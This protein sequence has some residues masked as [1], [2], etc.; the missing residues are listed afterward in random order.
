ML[1]NAYIDTRIE[2]L[3]EPSGSAEQDAAKLVQSVVGVTPA[4]D[5]PPRLFVLFLTRPFMPF[6][7]FVKSVRKQLNKAGLSDVPLIG[8]S[9]AAC[10]F[11]QNV[12]E[13]GAVLIGIASPHLEVSV[14]MAIGADRDAKAAATNLISQLDVESYS[15]G[16]L[17]SSY[18]MTFFPAD[19]SGNSEELI[20]AL[21]SRTGGQ[22][23]MF[24][25]GAVVV[26]DFSSGLIDDGYQ[27]LN[28]DILQGSVVAAFV[29]SELCFGLGVCDG[30][31]KK[32]DMLAKID[33]PASDVIE[34]LEDAKDARGTTVADLVQEHGSLT[35]FKLPGGEVILP[36]DDGTRLRLQGPIRNGTPLSV[37]V[38]DNRR[39]LKSVQDLEEYLAE[40]SY[41]SN[42]KLNAIFAIGSLL[43]YRHRHQLRFNPGYALT[44]AV[45]RHRGAHFVGVYMD[46]EL[47]VDRYGIS[48]LGRWSLAELML[49]DQLT[50]S[51]HNQLA[52]TALSESSGKTPST[53][54]EAISLALD[55]LNLAGYPRGMISM[56]FR[57]GED[58][59]V[60]GQDARGDRWLEPVLSETERKLGT[61]DVLATVAEDGKPVFVAHAPTDPRCACSGEGG[62]AEQANVISFVAIPLPSS[63]GETIG[64]LQVD[65]GDM[66][67]LNDIP[68]SDS[69]RLHAIASFAAT[70]INHAIKAEALE[71]VR[72]LD[73][74]QLDCL[75][76]DT[77]ESGL[78]RFIEEAATFLNVNAHIRLCQEDG[79]LKIIGGK[80]PYYEACL[81]G[82]VSVGFDDPR[83][84][85]SAALDVFDSGIPSIVNRAADEPRHQ[86]KLEIFADTPLG[87]AML[88]VGSYA[89]FPIQTD[90]QKPI[91]TYS[92]NSAERWFFT[93]SKRRSWADIGNRISYLIEHL[94]QKELQNR[95]L[96]ELSFILQITPTLDSQLNVYEALRTLARQIA[97]AANADAASFYLWDEI[98]SRFVL[99][100]QHGWHDE[101]WIDAAWHGH[102]SGLT[103][104]LAVKNSPTH[105]AD[106]TTERANRNLSTS[107]Y[108]N[109]VYP[110]RI[111]DSE[112]SEFIVIPLHFKNRESSAV[113]TLHRRYSRNC[114]PQSRGFTTVD[115]RIL[116]EAA[117]IISA[118]V[119]TLLEHDAIKWKAQEL[120]R[121]QK[122]LRVLATAKPMEKRIHEVCEAIRQEFRCRRCVLY[123][124]SDAKEIVVRVQAPRDG[125]ERVIPDEVVR[126]VFRTQTTERVRSP[127]SENQHDPDSVRIENQIC[128][129]ILPVHAGDRL[130]GVLDMSWVGM[131]N[132]R[133]R[134]VL[135]YHDEAAL[136]DLARQIGNSVHVD[137]LRREAQSAL[138]A[139]DGIAAY[140][141]DNF[142]TE[143]VKTVS[144]IKRKTEN[145]MNWPGP[146]N[147]HKELLQLSSVVNKQY[148]FVNRVKEFSRRFI[149]SRRAEHAI[150]E[151][152][153][154]AAERFRNE[155]DR[156]GIELKMDPV[157]R[158]CSFVDGVQVKEAFE[159]II[160]NA[161]HEMPNG[162]LL[163]LRLYRDEGEYEWVFEAEDSGPG[164]PPIEV[165]SE[166]R[167]RGGVG[168]W[169]A[170]LYCLS[171]N[172]QLILPEPGTSGGNGRG[173]SAQ[174]SGTKVSVR[175]PITETGL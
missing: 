59:W 142:H 22:L 92:F 133:H 115:P 25:G 85:M 129:V 12:H 86:E 64:V 74:I 137:N 105:V 50:E 91:G 35:A 116:N 155:I 156:R 11:D 100:A 175:M 37:V 80:G 40:F 26:E 108:A 150:D 78:C 162:G 75:S 54:P 17:R 15:G 73:E 114:P 163:E 49:A 68:E 20:S 9:V 132:N 88:Q 3:R 16:N 70:L 36:S 154:G 144:A 1:T 72:R 113:L 161:V 69:L 84:R 173:E 89:D 52:S 97:E 46:G 121:Q 82:R 30:L 157:D 96:K 4:G 141:R 174:G 136:L 126:Q 131:R 76:C 60:V 61:G 2:T 111:S 127:F 63:T 48:T 134:D 18:L 29:R 119:E 81:K 143:F 5:F 45:K 112:Q 23:M 32:G 153:L 110:T 41:V 6:D 58:Q 169:L 38:P 170:R 13:S 31:K 93:E 128:R 19:H 14:A 90:G 98:R 95:T 172:G 122:V 123:T 55:T 33:S 21:R 44:R 27:F 109:K 165:D 106:V 67:S 94:T 149:D 151:L 167:M 117:Q 160:G 62:L 166:S 135:P 79:R 164:F 120:A 83:S 145:I 10:L 159:T 99:R 139:L 124:G 51:R 103:G 71:F 43:R 140:L 47:G 39:I 34:C 146:A 56:L 28:G 7:G 118:S 101:N 87:D 24:G 8:A 148:G 53:V 65:L 66:R 158:V 104:T 152:V 168:L 77:L 130:Y 138:L 107:R 42:D 147:L 57:D 171:H 125:T 102:G